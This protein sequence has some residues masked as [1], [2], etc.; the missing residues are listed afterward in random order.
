MPVKSRIRS[1][2]IQ[3]LLLAAGILLLYLAFKGQDPKK[4][5]HELG[6]ADYR[7]VAGS[8][9]ALLGAHYF[10]ALRWKMLIR[11]LGFNPASFDVFCAVMIGYLAN[12]AV[13]RMGEVSRCAILNRTDKAPVDKLL[14]TV[15]TERIADVLMLLLLMVV[16]FVTQYSLISGFFRDQVLTGFVARSQSSG[17]LVIKLI[18]A[19]SILTGIVLFFYRRKKDIILDLAPVKKVRVFIAGLFE[20]IKSIRHMQRSWLFILYS[21]LIWALYAVSTALVFYALPA[22]SGLVLKTALFVLCAG[23]LG[24]VAPVQGGIGAYHFMVTQA[25]FLLGIAKSD[26]LAYATINHSSQLILFLLA[27]GLCVF[28]ILVLKPAMKLKAVSAETPGRTI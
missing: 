21:C 18:I 7:F 23:S 6:T 4:L 9:V 13:P 16:T 26:G 25:L 19:G 1:L 20:G 22:T 12:L 3:F 15:I 27:G 17:P 10:R 8:L 28:Y 2:F 24:M 5:L 11:P 14:G